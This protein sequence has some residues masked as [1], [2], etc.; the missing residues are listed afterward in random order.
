LG[1][2]AIIATS[3][4]TATKIDGSAATGSLTLTGGL[5]TTTILGGTASDKIVGGAIAETITSVAGDDTINGGSGA[6]VITAGAGIDSVTGGAD[7]DKFIIAT[8]DDDTAASSAAITDIITDFA[9]GSD[10]L[11]IG[12]TPASGVAVSITPAV[13]QEESFTIASTIII[14]E[15]FTL[16]GSTFTTTTNSVTDAAT[17]LAALYTLAGVTVSHNLGVVTLLANVA[18]TSFVVPSASTNS[19]GAT[20]T[21]AVVHAN[22]AQTTTGNYYEASAAVSDL[23]TLLADADTQLAGTVK[24]YVGQVGSDSYIVADDDFSGITDVIKLTGVTLSTI[25]AG[26]FDPS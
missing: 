14:G 2:G 26:D 7:A 5:L 17:G 3:G 10:M 25:A 19:A 13:A 8:A 9:T 15:T 16:G 1:S 12:A 6:D 4:D 21:P 22:A 18:G 23:A 24:Y 11:V 20:I